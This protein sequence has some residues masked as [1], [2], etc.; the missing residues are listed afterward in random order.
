MLSRGWLAVNFHGSKRDAHLVFLVI[1]RTSSRVKNGRITYV[2][3]WYG[4]AWFWLAPDKLPRL[5]RCNTGAR[6]IRCAGNTR[7]MNSHGLV[8]RCPDF[9][10]SFSQNVQRMDNQATHRWDC[11]RRPPVSASTVPLRSQ[12]HQIRR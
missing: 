7:K 8:P 4:T 2:H 5:I 9:F 10:R 1:F 6:S 12:R 3:R 11:S